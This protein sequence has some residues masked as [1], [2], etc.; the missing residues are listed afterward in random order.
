V[1][2]DERQMAMPKLVGGAAYGRPPQPIEASPRPFDPD[3]LPLEAERTDEEHA[4]AAALPNGVFAPGGAGAD[5]AAGSSGTGR[6]DGI[7]GILTR[8][9]RPS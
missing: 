9:L 6:T 5:R 1:T 2:F 3:E 4:F 7:R 8:L